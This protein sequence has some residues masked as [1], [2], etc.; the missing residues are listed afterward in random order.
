M[1]REPAH[2]WKTMSDISKTERRL[3]HNSGETPD[4]RGVL[5]GRDPE[6]VDLFGFEVI[7]TT[8]E[9]TLPRA[10]LLDKMRDVGLPDWMAPNVVAPHRAFGRMVDDLEEELNNRE[11]IQGLRINFDFE[12]GDSRYERHVHAR[13]WHGADDEDVNATAGKWDDHELGVIRYDSDLKG[14]TY[15][16]RIDEDKALGPLWYD[17]IKSRAEDRFE[18]HQELHNGKDINNMVYYLCRQWTDAVKLRDSCYFVPASYGGIE[19]YIDGFRELYQ[20]IDANYKQ[21]GQQT[22]LF[23]IEIVDS[24]RQREMVESKV[25]DE[26]EDEVGDIYDDIVDEV[27]DGAAVDEIAEEVVD[28]LANVEGAAE[29]HSAVLKTELSIKR[30]MADELDKLDDDREEVVQQALDEAGLAT[31]EEVEA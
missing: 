1:S 27:R 25:R 15:V 2:E 6:E 29:R 14:L 18:R 3:K 22:E 24:E 4:I 11:R 21:R 13:V 12:S 30:V 23:A 5:D 19:G 8:G 16:D 28:Q 7:Y 26:M 9:F 20:W 10:D 17:G 31:A